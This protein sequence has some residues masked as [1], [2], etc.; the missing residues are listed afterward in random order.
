MKRFEPSN[1]LDTA[2]YKNYLYNGRPLF[3]MLCY[4]TGNA[5]GRIT[6]ADKYVIVFTSRVRFMYKM[7]VYEAIGSCRRCS[8]GN[9]V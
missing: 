1:G 9:V 5:G 6:M 2:L 8:R 7:I 4:E 3:G